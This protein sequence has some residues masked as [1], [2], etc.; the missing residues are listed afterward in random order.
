MRL[1]DNPNLVSDTEEG[2]WGSA[3]WYW[4]KYVHDIPEVMISIIYLKFF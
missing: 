1:V 4:D 2:A 3:F